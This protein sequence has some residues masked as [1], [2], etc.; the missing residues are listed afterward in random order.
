MRTPRP[1]L[2]LWSCLGLTGC[3]LGLESY[4]KYT[5]S[6][7]TIDDGEDGGGVDGGGDG[8]SD[9]GLGDGGGDGGSGGAG[10]GGSGSGSGGSGSG[11]S[12]GDVDND[13][14]GYPA[15]YDCNDNDPSLNYDD[16]DGD[17]FA[18]CDGDC[19]DRDGFTYPGAAWAESSTLCM[20]DLDGDGYG[21][22]Y[23]ASGV[24]AGSDCD[25]RD[26]SIFPG[27][28]D[29]AGDGVDQDCDGAD[30]GS[31]GSTVTV[32]GTT[33][34][35]IDYFDNYYYA[36]VA[37][38]CTYVSD[39]SF[40]IDLDHSYLGDL[41]VVLHEPGGLTALIYDGGDW[42]SDGVADWDG[43]SSSITTT[44]NIGVGTATVYGEGTW[45]LLVQ[46]L[47]P[48][49]DGTLNSWSLTLTCY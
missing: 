12:G 24:T 37:S 46:D 8:A 47:D 49:L 14:D 32:S 1:A 29:P 16:Y 44:M 21:E 38:G 19:D 18:S 9:T 28:D 42:D 31:G 43:V 7:S 48:V 23:P 6:G 26:G 41:Y 2:I 35:I 36:T 3:G 11:G 20:T 27:A 30:T 45:T 25:D 34:T 13:G 22:M 39:I 15:S 33:G 4:A 10:S 17:T 5:D 40:S